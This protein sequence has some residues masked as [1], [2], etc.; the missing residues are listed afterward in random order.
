MDSYVDSHVEPL[1]K[2][3][4]VFAAGKVVLQS[5]NALFWVVSRADTIICKNRLF[6][7]TSRPVD[8]IAENSQNSLLRW[9]Q[10]TNRPQHEQERNIFRQ[11]IDDNDSRLHQGQHPPF[12]SKRKWEQC[13]SSMILLATFIN[14]NK[15]DKT[16]TEGFIAQRRLAREIANLHRDDDI[17]IDVNNYLWGHLNCMALMWC[18]D[19]FLL[20][21]STPEPLCWW[22]LGFEKFSSGYCHFWVFFVVMDMIMMLYQRSDKILLYIIL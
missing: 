18:H 8:I 22:S 21:K 2:L 19:L 16:N 12:I 7:W 10:T 3:S 5:F 20:Q 6:S 15:R 9:R 11:I 14:N 1:D 17:N 13:H 4:S